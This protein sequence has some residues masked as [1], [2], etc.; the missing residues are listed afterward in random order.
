MV[1]VDRSIRA[2]ISLTIRREVLPG[3]YGGSGPA[4]LA[5]ALLADVFDDDG[6][7]L[8]YHQDFKWNVI[9]RLKQNEPWTMEE[10]DIRAAFHLLPK[11]AQ[12]GATS[13]T[14]H[15]LKS[16]PEFFEA[17]QSDEKTFEVRFNDRNY[18][19]GDVLHLREWEPANET[20][21]GR[22]LKLLVTYVLAGLGPGQIEPLR[23]IV[24]GY[25]V[26]G[27]KP[28][29]EPGPVSTI[30]QDQHTLFQEPTE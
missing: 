2:S 29:E 3:A 18:T 9:A 30:N 20:Y 19:K 11:K 6:L 23:G 4:Q 15:E 12:S 1:S 27:F 16:W 28:T 17:I 22:N 26:L 8:R 14:T 10:A 25:C 7:A 21:T 24:K 5:L 13:M